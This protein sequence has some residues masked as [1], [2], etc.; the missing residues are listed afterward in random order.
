MKQI[1]L[2][3]AGML[4][5][6]TP[7]A[8]E[9]SKAETLKSFLDGTIAFNASDINQHEPLISLR[10]LASENADKT[11]QLTKENIR[12][13]I[14]E[15]K[16]YSSAVV[17]VGKHTIAKITSVDDC[18]Q[19]GAWGVCMPKSTGYVQKQGQLI[20]HDNYLNFII[21]VPDSQERTLY[22]FK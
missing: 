17:I 8:Q 4:M 3:I 7:K 19:S 20:T 18:Q 9:Q 5:I 13:S 14:E 2:I 11:I 21:G 1:L 15:M 12:T 16:D 22:L 10:K 6:T